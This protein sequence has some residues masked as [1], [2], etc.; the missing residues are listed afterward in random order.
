MQ[1]LVNVLKPPVNPAQTLDDRRFLARQARDRHLAHA[2]MTELAGLLSPTLMDPVQPADP[3]LRAVGAIGRW[4]GMDIHPPLSSDD[5]ERGGHPLEAIAHASRIRIR[6]VQLTDNWWRK[7]G[8]PLL[9][10]RRE[11]H[12]PVALLP[13]SATQ[14]Q[15]FDP[16]DFSYIPVTQHLRQQLLPDAY[17][18]YRALPD[19]ALTALDVWR[20]GLHRQWPNLRTI[21]L[22]GMAVTGLGMLTPQATAILID[23]T[24]PDGNRS[25][26]CQ[27]GLGLLAATLGGSIFRFV[28]GVALLRIESTASAATQAA[29][30]DALLRLPM[31]F[32]RQYSTGDLEARVSAINHIRQRLSGTTLS[33]LLL[34]GFSLLNLGLLFYYSVPLAGL[35]VLVAGL[36]VGLTLLSGWQ[37]LHVVRPLENLR[38]Q[39]RGL[40]IQLIGGVAKLRVA[41]AEIRAF[42][43][44]SQQYSQL[45]RW[46]LRAEQV[47]N[48]LLVW[49][50]LLPILSTIA[51][52]SVAVG[53]FQSGSSV[54]IGTFL[55][56]HTA[57]GSFVAGATALSNALMTL[58]DTV[59][60]WERAKPILT[61]HPEVDRSKA[62]PGRLAGH[63]RVEHITFGYG[64]DG[65]A[66]LEDVCLEAKP[67]EFIAIV[68]P[69]GSGKSTLLRLLL[70]FERPHTGA[71]YYDGQDLSGLALDAV[72]R[73]MGVVLQQSQVLS[74]SIFE[75]IAGSAPIT[76]QDAW[77]AARCA[78]FAEDIATMPMGMHTVVSEGGSNL[79]GGQRQRLLIARAIVQRPQILLLDE[80]TSA[81]DNHTQ[82][83]VSASLEQLHV[84]RIVI[85]HRLSTIRQ[86]D[87]IYVMQAGKI[88]QQGHFEALVQ[89]PG[90]FAQLVTRQLA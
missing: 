42:A 81:L 6:R 49:N 15:L 28:Q 20:F 83:I 7:D 58:L 75:N 4:L 55:A 47:E 60:L 71:I 67:G 69:S 74:A 35:A 12:R 19:S 21:L 22:S 29:V 46:V 88:V 56:F 8:G 80:A 43:H 73:Q 66:T 84:T 37:M 36:S 50:D 18:F 61:T 27:L 14:Y 34:G 9:A 32:F 90:L 41:A 54:S 30:W 68:G 63:V 23:A 72:R 2:A 10:Y 77:W 39:V 65:V 85:A 57:F 48:R 76:L 70:G 11:D 79:S 3:L 62:D 24:I 1:R 78:G 16:V 87:R 59:S 82:Q 40:T 44:W 64:T 38:G 26:L 52:Y 51:L 86:A 13:V 33:S 31:P 53:S 45:Q 5:V 17:T 89:Q 25:L